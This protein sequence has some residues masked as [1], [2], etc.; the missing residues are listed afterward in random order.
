M[1]TRG[2]YSDSD[3]CF[4]TLN[5]LRNTSWL[6]SNPLNICS[7]GTQICLTELTHFPWL[8][9]WKK[10]IHMTSNSWDTSLLPHPEPHYLIPLSDIR[11]SLPNNP[12]RFTLILASSADSIQLWASMILIPTLKAKTS[13]NQLQ[14]LPAAASQKAVCE[15]ADNT[16]WAKISE[17]PFE[18]NQLACKLMLERGLQAFVCPER[19]LSIWLWLALS[20]SDS[21]LSNSLCQPLT[22]SH[23]TQL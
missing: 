16:S 10:Y 19:K 23:R 8:Q 15:N 7:R 13:E 1:L 3:L 20:L 6:S 18:P 9:I 5:Q 12:L 14:D 11:T 21:H 2:I 4:K 17:L 22:L